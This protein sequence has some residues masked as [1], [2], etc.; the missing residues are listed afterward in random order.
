M[1]QKRR[2]TVG[3]AGETRFEEGWFRGAFQICGIS[4][5]PRVYTKRREREL[6]AFVILRPF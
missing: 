2:D 4:A 3:R 1:T 5:D 6:A